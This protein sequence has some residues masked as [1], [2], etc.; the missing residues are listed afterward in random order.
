MDSFVGRCSKFNEV[1][2][3]HAIP[4]MEWKTVCCKIALMPI[5]FHEVDKRRHMRV[6]V[7]ITFFYLE[8]RIHILFNNVLS[9]SY[10]IL[11]IVVNQ[12]RVFH[13]IFQEMRGEDSGAN[14][15]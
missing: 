4:A 3:F 9:I 1:A 8:V 11:K 13:H 14:E 12:V 15:H 7:F 10:S 2:C 5:F 6:K